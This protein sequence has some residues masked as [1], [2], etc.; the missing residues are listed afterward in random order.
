VSWGYK[1]NFSKWNGFLHFQDIK[2]RKT[3]YIISLHIVFIYFFFFLFLS[4]DTG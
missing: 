1:V 2:Y 3:K 4:R